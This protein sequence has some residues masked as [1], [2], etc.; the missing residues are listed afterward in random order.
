M[1]LLSH[2]QRGRRPDNRERSGHPCG[3]RSDGLSRV[4]PLFPR[5]SGVH[6]DKASASGKMRVSRQTITNWLEKGAG[7]FKDVLAYLKDNCLE[8]DSV[9]N[10][11]ET[12]AV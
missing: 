5:H 12:C 1:R 6:G 3:S 11:D 9:V 8:K 2:G 10:C 4:Q 7:Y